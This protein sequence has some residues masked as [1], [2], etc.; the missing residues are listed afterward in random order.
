MLPL[1]QRN[2]PFGIAGAADITQLQ[3]GFIS[4]VST[5]QCRRKLGGFA[6]TNWQQTGRHRI[7]RAGMPRLGCGKQALGDLQRL[8]GGNS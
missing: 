3:R 6:E 8:I 5:Q 2:F 4:L 1:Q 7:Q